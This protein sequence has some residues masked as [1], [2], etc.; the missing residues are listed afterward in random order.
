MRRCIVSSLVA[1]CLATGLHAQNATAPTAIEL[2]GDQHWVDTGIDVHIG[3]T[4]AITATGSM[5][6][7]QSKANGP[8]GLA[9]GWKD[10]LRSMP[11]VDA[12]RG[13]VVGRIG[14]AETAQPFL[15]G[16]RREM[17]AVRAGRLFVGINQP[18]SDSA[19]G[20][21]QVSIAMTAAKVDSTKKPVNAHVP[22]I[23]VAMLDK[24]PARIGDLDGNVGDRV[25]FLVVGSEDKVKEAFQAAGWVQVDRETKDA[26]LHGLMAS[27]SKQAYL[28][29]PMSVLYLF[30]RPQDFG[31]AHAEP[32]A[33]VSTRHHL[34]LWKAPFEVEGQTVWAGAAT[35][36]IG[37]EKD[38]RNGKVTHK[39]DPNVDL[40]R[41][42]VGQSL[43]ETGL[44]AK[45]SYVTPSQPIKEAKTA[46][47]GSFHS[48][49]RTEIIVLNAPGADETGKFADIFCSVLDQ[50]SDAGN[51]GACSQYLETPSQTKLTL[52]PI[53]NK[54]RLLIVPGIMNS[55]ASAAP[56]FDEG[57][58]VLRDK[59]GMT[60]ELLAV[61]NDAS[62]VNAKTIAQY[63]KDHTK[64]DQR[65]YIVLGYSKGA[66]DL[67]TMLAT[68]KEA[69]GLVAAF[70]TVAGAVGGSPIADFLPAQLDKYMQM[71]KFGNCKGDVSTGFKSLRRDVRQAFLASYPNPIVPS[72]SVAAVSDP[73]NTSKMLLESWKLLSVYDSKQDSQLTR[74]DSIIPGAKYLGTARADHLAVGLPLDKLADKSLLSFLDHGKYPRAA[75]LESLVR[76]VIQ[77]LDTAN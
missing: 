76:Y 14:S 31:F 68:D 74:Q 60:V 43:D 77:D 54:Y 53:P 10:L 66:P 47:G 33:V 49:G 72:Y 18:A 17:T 21:F 32:I 73:S 28:E 30:G 63:L 13:S 59:Y 29:M 22:E 70:V 23:T 2:K 12:G 69:A 42:F 46:T 36:D 15:I 11:V 57:Q 55:C 34:R 35:H 58:K 8:E 40:E 1:L 20:S 75:L 3:D 62:E 38:Q 6:Y 19:Q 41:D 65:K 64:D 67:Q 16:P 24:I 45:L 48:D 71:M 9:R 27:L 26:V 61:P 51:W 37:F 44:V 39:I 5:L 52:A 4:L 50:N 7:P 25:N 56:A